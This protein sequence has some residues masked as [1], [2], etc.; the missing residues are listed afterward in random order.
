LAA[1]GSAELA[2]RGLS[3]WR[4]DLALRLGVSGGTLVDLFSPRPLPPALLVQRLEFTFETY[5]GRFG[6]LTLSMPDPIYW[7]ADLVGLASL[8]GLALALRRRRDL[9]A[10]ALCALCAISALAIGVGPFLVGAMGDEMPQGRYLYPAIL[11]ISGLLAAGLARL[12]PRRWAA[13]GL[14]LF[15]VGGVVVNLVAMMA[16]LLPRYTG[17][18]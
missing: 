7:L 4:A 8:V 2:E 10:L 13:L 1:N 16:A 3:P 5:L 6:W 18:I 12:W 14:A 17:A 9:A 15:V 11:P